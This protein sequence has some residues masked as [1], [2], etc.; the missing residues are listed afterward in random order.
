M[1]L[2]PGAGDPGRF[3]KSNYAYY[4]LGFQKAALFA[5]CV[6]FQPSPSLIL[7]DSPILQVEKCAE[8]EQKDCNKTRKMEKRDARMEREIPGDIIGVRGV[9]KPSSWM[10]PL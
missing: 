10:S 6:P 4:W 5:E 3:L 7:P 9:P 8:G 1:C 2:F